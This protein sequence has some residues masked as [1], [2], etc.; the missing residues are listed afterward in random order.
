MKKI[1]LGVIG[2][3]TRGEVAD[4]A[5]NRADGVEIVAGADLYPAAQKAFQE[6]FAGKFPGDPLPRV[7]ADYREMIVKESPDGVF[8]TAPDFLHEEMALF[9]LEHHVA[10]YLEKPMALTIQGCDRIL[11]SARRNRTVLMLGHNMRY[12]NYIRKMK[13]I[14]D[15]GVIGAVKTIWCRHFISYGGDAYFRDW[16]ADAAK[17]N[18]LLLQKGAHDIDVIHYL[19]G[20]PTVRVA[21]IGNLSVYDKLPRRAPDEKQLKG[22]VAA[23]WSDDHYPPE[24]QKDFYPVISVNDLNMIQMTLG[25]GILASY[26]QCHYT[27]DQSRNYTVIGT[28]GRLENYGDE[29]VQ[30]WTTRRD[31][32]WRMEGDITYRLSKGT[33]THGGADVRIIASFVELLRGIYDHLGAT[34]QEARYSVACGCQGADSIRRGGVPLDVPSLAEEVENWDFFRCGPRGQ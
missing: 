20:A 12:M 23:H 17:S 25:N 34:P 26:L 18:S 9:A 30:V 10:V 19:A 22:G 32:S 15:S 3:T 5:Q 29:A 6:R 27:P 4:Y 2:C 1:R 28:R 8:I 16:H 21:G 14:I 7:Y 33:G 24:T 31:F 11:E 13:E